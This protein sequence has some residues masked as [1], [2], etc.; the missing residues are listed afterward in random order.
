M[1]GSRQQAAAAGLSDSPVVQPAAS[2]LV[3]NGASVDPPTR[4]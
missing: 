4:C 2:N 3:V 1:N